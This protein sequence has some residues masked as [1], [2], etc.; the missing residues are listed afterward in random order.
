MM[1]ASRRISFQVETS[2][3]WIIMAHVTAN[4][5]WVVEAGARV[6]EKK[7]AEG[8]ERLA[9]WE[10]LVYALWVADY[11]MRNGE[12]LRF[13]RNHMVDFSTIGM[14]VAK[15]LALPR[16]QELFSMDLCAFEAEYL[17][18]FEEVCDEIRRAGLER[19]PAS[20]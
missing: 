19:Q 14:R 9:P 16:T 2:P 18:R 15:E 1:H 20:D 8:F 3:S 13:S 7:C 11:A 10:T 5:T 4:E 17:E 6:I 12:D